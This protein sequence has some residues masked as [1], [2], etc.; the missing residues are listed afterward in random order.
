METVSRNSPN[1]GVTAT[2]SQ[3]ENTAK[4]QCGVESKST[5]DHIRSS[6]PEDGTDAETDEESARSESNMRF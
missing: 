2:G 3:T 6:S 4:E 5:T 1:P